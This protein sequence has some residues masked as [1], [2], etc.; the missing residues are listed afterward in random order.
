MYRNGTGILFNLIDENP[1]LLF[2][3]KG[4]ICCIEDPLN[5]KNLIKVD[6]SKTELNTCSDS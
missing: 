6:F 2:C 1:A 3:S 5:L 4:F